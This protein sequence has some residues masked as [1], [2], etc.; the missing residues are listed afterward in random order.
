[1]A[2]AEINCCSKSA[3]TNVYKDFKCFNEHANPQ[4]LK[5]L[6][7]LSIKGSL[8]KQKNTIETKVFSRIPA[9]ASHISHA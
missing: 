6:L 2:I 8:I 9:M 5:R 1:M 4:L 3:S 7:D